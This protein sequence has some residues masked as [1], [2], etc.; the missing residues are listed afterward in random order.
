MHR[1]PDATCISERDLTVD[2]RLW[3]CQLDDGG[4]LLCPEAARSLSS[5]KRRSSVPPLGVG[6]RGAPPRASGRQECPAA[7]S[8]GV[9]MRV[10]ETL[11]AGDRRPFPRRSHCGHGPPARAIPGRVLRR[12]SR[13]ARR[14]SRRPLP[15]LIRR[16][17]CPEVRAAQPER[18]L[19]AIRRPQTARPHSVLRLSRP[20]AQSDRIPK[21]TGGVMR[22]SPGIQ[23]A[24]VSFNTPVERHVADLVSSKGRRRWNQERWPSE[25]CLR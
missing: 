20:V 11:T 1:R 24:Y 19:V 8:A 14:G 22:R 10:L 7:G 3:R 25:R 9:W 16:M 12:S 18:Y 13:W 4:A 5:K 15:R 17:P 23:W 6:R 21:R 2:H